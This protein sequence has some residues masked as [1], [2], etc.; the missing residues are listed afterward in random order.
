MLFVISIDHSSK[1]VKTLGALSYQGVEPQALDGTCILEI[2]YYCFM[3]SLDDERDK[4]DGFPAMS[5][6]SL[7]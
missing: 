3:I 4:E 6:R 1:Q 5:S 2:H 7:V